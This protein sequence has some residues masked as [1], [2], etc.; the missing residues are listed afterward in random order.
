MSDD[1]IFADES[2]TENE[3]PKEV[4]KLFVVDD[5]EEVHRVTKMVLKDFNFNNKNISLLNAYSGKEAMKILQENSDIAVILLDVV[6]EESDSGLKLVKYIRDDLKNKNS[7]IILRTG[8]PG[9]APEE[10]VIVEYDINDY[11]SKTE[12]TSQ[13]LFTSV[14]SALRSYQDIVTIEKNKIGLKKIIEASAKIFE[15]QSMRKFASGVLTQLTSL[16]NVNKDALYFRVSGFSAVNEGSGDFYVL[17]ATG[18][19]ENNISKRIEDIINDDVC[20]ELKNI[21]SGQQYYYDGKHYLRYIVSKNKAENIIYLDGCN[22]LSELDKELVDIFCMNVSIAYDNLYLNKELEES[23]KELI[24]TLGEIVENRS[25]ETGAHVKRVSEI[26]RFLALKSGIEDETA[27]VIG[28]ASAMHDIGKLGIPDNILTKPAKLDNDEYTV[29]KTH[30]PIGN[31]MLK[32][33][34]RNIL[35]LAST[36]AL[37][38]HER[39]DGSG[40]PNG[41]KGEEIN[42]YARM[43][44][45]ADVF[46]ALSNDRVYRKSWTIDEIIKYFNEQKGKHFDPQLTE[47]FLNNLTDILKIAKQA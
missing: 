28:V 11:K 36:I 18:S 37:Q 1:L 46:D 4:W 26:V 32:F 10:K 44:A 8:Q 40:Y 29:M 24:Y 2:A 45:I 41:L 23:Q 6:M 13:K 21:R 25:K 30:S 12:L 35:K 7:R 42:I 34:N 38:H 16:I 22:N 17:A 3:C 14:I 43:T 27:E 47:V 20:K 19:F 31:D 9:Q 5:E 33:S 39:Y 15:M